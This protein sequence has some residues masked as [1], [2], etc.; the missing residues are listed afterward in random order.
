MKFN[1]ILLGSVFFWKFPVAIL[2][3]RKKINMRY[4]FTLLYLFVGIKIFAQPQ[5]TQ[6]LKGQVIDQDVRYE[7]IGA[8]VAV[9]QEAA[10][11]QGCKTNEKGEF[12]LENIPVGRYKVVVSYVG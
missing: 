6:T 11:I 8:N 5:L 3:F 9:Y 1:G 10:L 7:L 2:Y 12:K 4:F